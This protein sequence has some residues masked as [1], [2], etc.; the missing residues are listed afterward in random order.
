MSEG[1]PGG[2]RKVETASRRRIAE[3]NDEL[4]KLRRS[5]GELKALLESS[6][7]PML[8]VDLE[9]TLRS[10]TPSAGEL[11][12]LNDADLGRPVLELVS[13]LAG[14][15]FEQEMSR[16]AST[17]A[18]VE[19]EIETAGGR[20]HLGRLLPCNDPQ[21]GL[22]LT[23]TDITERKRT[24]EH[25]NLRLAELGHRIKNTLAVVQSIAAQTMRRSTSPEIFFQKFSQRLQ[26]FARAHDLLSTGQWH[27][28]R[29]REIVTETVAPHETASGRIAIQGEDFE[30][31]PSTALSLSL[32]LH[33]LTTNAV[34]HGALSGPS[35]RVGIA[36]G[37]TE[38]EQGPA[39]RFIWRETGG[40]GAAVPA[41]HGFGL[42]L[43]ERGVGYEL[44][45]SVRLDFAPEGLTCEMVIPL[46][47]RN[48]RL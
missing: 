39:L 8:R 40:P 47:A 14:A 12:G 26:A 15:G 6:K 25:Q 46:S 4:E 27:S 13:S 35:G 23:F 44:E 24:E 17:R 22:V 45:G 38:A 11:L 7:I 2:A 36:W 30:L 34:K 21:G 32:V 20:S 48:F 37:L 5:Y 16:V 1:E 9:M 43:I 28:A 19:R 41:E 42:M 29:L 18:V 33:E 31:K 3:L 10:F